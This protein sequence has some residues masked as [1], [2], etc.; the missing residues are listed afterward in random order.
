MSN[1][2]FDTLLTTTL[3]NFRNKL[4]DN[5][6]SARPF[7]YWL[8]DKGRMRSVSGGVKIVEQLIYAANTTAGSYS[9]YDTI[10]LTPQTGLTAAEYDWKQFAASI[11]I[12]GLEEAQNAGEE[13]L[14]DLLEAK[15][16]Q[17]EETLKESFD[18]M[19]LTSDGTGNS[20]KDWLGLPA[21]VG[22]DTTSI[23]SVGGIEG[24]TQ[25]YWRSYVEDTAAALTLAQ[26]STGFNSTAQGNDQ[27]DLAL[28]TQTLYER[29]EALLQPNQRFTDP[30]TAQAGF[31]NLLY[32][33]AVTMWDDYTVAGNWYFLNS[34]YLKLVTHKSN[35]MK[36][37]PFVRP[38]N[39]DARYALII[40]YGNLTCSNRSRQGLLSGK[41]A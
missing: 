5:I 38:E 3:N 36:Q 40:C 12:S 27:P 37:T 39:M 23:T 14:I 28:T 21:I 41:T 17:T 18:E 7:Q 13:E 32:K 26:L 19:F 31:Q 6:F 30:K 9:G 2:N 34:K 15:V 22:D 35:W 25:A 29:Y 10:A 16:M 11:A 24:A 33:G 8:L 4:T 20:G 1:P